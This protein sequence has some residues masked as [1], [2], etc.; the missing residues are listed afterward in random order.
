MEKQEIFDKVATHLA[1]QGRQAALNNEACVYRT[2]DGLKCAAG[3]LIP[4]DVYQPSMEG[5]PIDI[6][7]EGYEGLDN[8]RSNHPIILSLQRAHDD[9]SLWAPKGVENSALK[10]RLRS[11]AKIHMLNDT[12]LNSLDFTSKH[13]QFGFYIQT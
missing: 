6:I 1:T 5:K 12:I 8:L 4:D 7:I 9:G 13:E 2:S 3:I 10:D 11:I